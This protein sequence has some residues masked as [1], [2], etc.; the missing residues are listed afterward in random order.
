MRPRILRRMV[1][2]VTALAMGAAA[3]GGD[4]GPAVA[5]LE[6]DGD[7]AALIEVAGSGGFSDAPA[8]AIEALQ[9]LADPAT[10]PLLADALAAESWP[11]GEYATPGGVIEVLG[12]VGGAAAADVIVGYVRTSDP[13]ETAWPEQQ[14]TWALTAI[15]A[16]AYPTLA[17]LVE[18]PVPAATDPAAAVDTTLRRLATLVLGGRAADARD[19]FGRD[20]RLVPPTS[21]GPLGSDRAEQ[22]LLA[23]LEVAPQCTV[24]SSGVCS[25]TGWGE[26]AAVSLVLRR[27]A[28]P[29]PLFALLDDPATARV[30]QGL[31]LLGTPGSEPA[32]VAALQRTP[33][34][35]PLGE[36]L[37]STYANSGNAVLE[38]AASAWRDA[39]GYTTAPAFCPASQLGGTCESVSL[40]G[41]ID[42]L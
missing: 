2:T 33:G 3:C 6:A 25:C 36:S 31:V 9:R 15:G 20:Q 13:M 29:A 1:V 32:L 39:H 14:I 7:V 28:D 37:M 30:A 26:G 41:S 22:A 42:D 23:A 17:P 16:D 4:S 40:W 8:E 18:A 11:S 24:T 27:R 21:T 35:T 5:E 34:S 12:A 19:P 38:D 10:V